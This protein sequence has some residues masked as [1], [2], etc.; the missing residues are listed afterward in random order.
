M[1]ATAEPTGLRLPGATIVPGDDPHAQPK[2][3]VFC[4]AVIRL[5][6]AQGP[7]WVT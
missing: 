3:N 4:P 5:A 7:R 2:I 1:Q 6:V